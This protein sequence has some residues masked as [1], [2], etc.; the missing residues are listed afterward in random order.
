MVAQDEDLGVL[1]AIGTGIRRRG[2]QMPAARCPGID[3]SVTAPMTVP[4]ELA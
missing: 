4:P 1:G 2:A 3:K